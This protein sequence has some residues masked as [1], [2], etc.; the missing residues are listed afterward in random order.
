MLRPF[1]IVSSDIVYDAGVAEFQFPRTTKGSSKCA[2]IG[3]SHRLEGTFVQGFGTIL[4]KLSVAGRNYFRGRT[5]LPL[6]SNEVAGIGAVGNVQN[7]ANRF[8]GTHLTNPFSY[9][10]G[11]SRCSGMAIDGSEEIVMR[12]E[13]LVPLGPAVVTQVTL[14]CVQWPDDES[15]QSEWDAM[16]TH[17]IG[18]TYFEG[19]EQIGY[20]ASGDGFEFT[21]KPAPPSSRA[22]RRL[23]FRGVLTND[24]GIVFGLETTT[25]ATPGFSNLIMEVDG[26]FSRPP[27]NRFANARSMA[28]LLGFPTLAGIYDMQRNERSIVRILSVGAGVA[29]NPALNIYILHMFEGRNFKTPPNGLL[30]SATAIS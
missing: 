12:L 26:D 30:N 18:E 4:T 3:I 17:G 13:Q 29:A 19:S 2:I 25:D 22:L 14:W 8:L 21:V 6:V 9:L 5:P 16:Y 20:P 27:Q 28:G 7:S 15:E 11:N 10:G 1:S 24:L 23:G